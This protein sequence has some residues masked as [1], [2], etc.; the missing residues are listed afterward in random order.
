[1]N[2]FMALDMAADCYPERVAVRSDDQS[3]TFGELPQA[4]RGTAGRIRASSVR[5]VGLLD[6]NSPA[7]LA[8]L[9][10]AA[11]GPELRAAFDRIWAMAADTPLGPWPPS[12]YLDRV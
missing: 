12:P 6:V 3:L 4:A 2:L 11:S 8:E 10:A 7:S 1:M 9:I 5:H